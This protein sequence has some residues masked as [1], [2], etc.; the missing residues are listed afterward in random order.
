MTS[1]DPCSSLPA[2]AMTSGA[3]VIELSSDDEEEPVPSTTAL[4]RRRPSSPPDVKPPLLADA[5]VKPLLL[6]PPGYGALVPVKT[7]EPEPSLVPSSATATR[8]RG[9]RFPASRDASLP[10]ALRLL[11]HPD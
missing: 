10:L 1:V 11:L 5:D 9:L 3:E 6:H 7:E 8:G 4:A 2:P